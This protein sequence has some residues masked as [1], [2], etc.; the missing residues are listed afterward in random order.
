MQLL[1]RQSLRSSLQLTRTTARP[2]Q[3]PHIRPTPPSGFPERPTIRSFS[4]CLQ[5]QFHRLP[6][7]YSPLDEKE[8]R[9]AELERIIQSSRQG[10]AAEGVPDKDEAAGIPRADSSESSMPL[11]GE[12]GV[13]QDN[14][15]YLQGPEAEQRSEKAQN[16]TAGAQS[17]G[18][19]SYLENRRSQMSKQFT[20]MM[21]NVQANIF[22]AGQ[23][24]NDLTGYS[25]IETLKR[26]IQ[27]QGTNGHH[28]SRWSLC[29]ST[30]MAILL[31]LQK[32]ASVKLAFTSA[33]PRKHT[34]LRSTTAPPRSAKSTSSSNAS[35]PG[36]QQTWS[37]S[38]SSTATTTPTRS[39]R[40]RHKRLCLAQSVRLKRPPHR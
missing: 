32:P 31:P 14:V 35:M 5:C 33:K 20:T 16:S 18:L 11:A 4:V 38:P 3:L 1:L 28:T 7:S 37:A 17:R 15:I 2:V 36:P 29:T 30:N 27:T 13:K 8:R 19:P 9:E 23:R 12:T 40:Q 6:G 24:L 10:F 26:D 21:D 25:A 39:P 34:Q 22:V